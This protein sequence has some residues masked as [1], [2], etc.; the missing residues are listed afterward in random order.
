MYK[1]FILRGIRNNGDIWTPFMIS[2]SNVI[3]L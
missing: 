1:I 2:N 3:G